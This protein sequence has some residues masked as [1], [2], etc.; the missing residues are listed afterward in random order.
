MKT[1]WLCV[2]LYLKLGQMGRLGWHSA[3]LHKRVR[4]RH[5]YSK[6]IVNL[7]FFFAIKLEGDGSRWQREY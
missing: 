1:L 3:F 7:E 2:V 5:A 4:L 6:S